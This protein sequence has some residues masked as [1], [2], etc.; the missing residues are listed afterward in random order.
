MT[1]L[2]VKR[3]L[4]SVSDKEGIIPFAKAL[5][6][7]GIDIISTGGTAQLLRQENI[8]VMEASELTGFPEI[9]D[10]RVKTL[11]PKIHAGILGKRKE[12]AEVAKA[13]DI[14][15]IDLVVVNL[16][17]FVQVTKTHHHFEEALE[18]IDIGGP[19]MI[20]AAAKNMAHVS[21]IVDPCDYEQ[22]IA[23]LQNQGGLT[24]AHRKS[25][26]QKAF[27]HTARYDDY[28]AQYLANNDQADFQ[29]F[30]LMP[31]KKAF[32]LRYGENPHQKAA[33][34]HLEQAG[35]GILD[36][37]IHQGKPLSYNNLLDTN[38][39]LACVQEFESDACVIVKHCNPCGVALG[40]TI[41]KAFKQAQQADSTAAFGGIIALNRPCDLDTAKA[42]C[43]TFFEVLIAPDFTD[44][45]LQHLTGKPALRVLQLPM[46]ALE[47]RIDYQFI[48]GGLL[49]QT[50]GCDIPDVRQ[51]QVVTDKTPTSQEMDAL[52]FAWK[53]VKHVK[54]NAIVLAKNN[55]TL[56]IGPG[57]V[58][59]VDAVETALRKASDTAQGAILASDAFFPFRDSIDL[60]AKAGVTAL[61]QPGG[62]IRDQ[63][64][65]DACNQQGLA[66]VFTGIRCFKH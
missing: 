38:A 59:R 10:G 22:V 52:L 63:E 25:L 37:K 45:A 56:G 50:T 30:L 18:N 54:S 13:H 44:D 47:N 4:I 11:H 31:L 6:D 41:L 40:A 35:F 66:M 29:N 60:L 8:N 28:I 17:P 48:Q 34:Y 24:E 57:Q 27:M 3:A 23:L 15:W 7:I 14:Q 39:A 58:S 65:I 43:E 62:S 46:R 19:T 61:I 64:V 9:M 26:A 36:A 1:Y 12:H 55:Q 32:N 2:P 21:V 20:R 51:W 53:V 16:Y 5:Q 49:M 33:A 42:I